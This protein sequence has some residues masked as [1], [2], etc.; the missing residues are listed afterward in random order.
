[1]S[2]RNFT[3]SF[4]LST[5]TFSVPELQALYSRLQRASPTIG[6]ILDRIPSQTVSGFPTNLR[7]RPITGITITDDWQVLGLS[8]E[9][10]VPAAAGFVN[11]RIV[12]FLN[13][14]TSASIAG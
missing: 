5:G 14:R 3:P 7:N 13:P 9:P 6:E 11:G 2:A 4:S 12:V 8:A 10:S 1:M